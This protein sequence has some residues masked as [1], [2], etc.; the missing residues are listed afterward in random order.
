MNRLI[1]LAG[2]ILALVGC[3]T[4]NTP[5]PTAPATDPPTQ[6]VPTPTPLPPTPTPVEIPVQVTAELANCRFGPGT[7]YLTMNEI[8]SGRLLT[9]VGRDE[10]SAWWQVEDPINPGGFCWVSANVTDEQGDVNQLPVVAAPFVTVTKLDLRVEP[11]R[12]VVNCSDFP[13][14]VFFE[15]AISANGPTLLTWQWEASTGVASDVG[16]LI[17]EEAGTQVINEFYRINAPN[18][19]WVKLKILTPNEIVEQV[20]FPV[21]CTP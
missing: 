12:I 14:T 17:Y 9:A 18:E 8:R 15:A 13:Q 11:N 7:V 20:S 10:T 21:S 4:Q 19:Y 2:F 16:T 5:P 6:A 1:L 3:T